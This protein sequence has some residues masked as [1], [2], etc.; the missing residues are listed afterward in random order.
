[1]ETFSR[2]SSGKTKSFPPCTQNGTQNR[3]KRY[4]ELLTG[5]EV[6]E[7]DRKLSI[8]KEQLRK[9]KRVCKNLQLKRDRMKR[10]IA[11]QAG[12]DCF[13]L[14]ILPQFSREAVQ[15]LDDEMRLCKEDL[16]YVL[17]IDGQGRSVIQKF[18]ETR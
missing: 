5:I 4:I 12:K 3:K 2:K 18:T 7:G 8:L 9:E 6:I 1:M 16:Q 10:H 14:K 11:F 15:D 17:R 13:S